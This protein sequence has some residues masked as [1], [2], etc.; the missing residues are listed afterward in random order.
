MHVFAI[1]L[2]A[3]L[4]NCYEA[5]AF[6]STMFVVAFA[7]GALIKSWRHVIP[8]A[9]AI[10]VAA[11]ITAALAQF[12]FDGYAF[13][14]LPR[15]YP[16]EQA[17]YWFDRLIIL[18][19]IIAE[20]FLVLL[21][22]SV[23]RS[24]IGGIIGRVLGYAAAVAAIAFGGS[25]IFDYFRAPVGEPL[26]PPER[27]AKI[28]R[29]LGAA[30]DSRCFTNPAQRL[31]IPTAGREVAKSPPADMPPTAYDATPL[32]QGG[33]GAMRDNG[34][35]ITP[36][37]G[38]RTPNFGSYPQDDYFVALRVVVGTDGRVL[39]AKP[40]EGPPDAFPAAIQIAERL[41][42]VPFLRDGKP[43][44]VRLEHV[45]V[46]TGPPARMPKKTVA[47]PAVGD[48]SML[49][50]HLA[51][52]FEYFNN[53]A[54]AVTI[55]GDGAVRFEGLNNVALM[56]EH[57]AL[58]APEAVDALVAAFRAADFHSLDDAYVSKTTYEEEPAV[59]V[60]ITIGEQ[61]KTVVSYNGFAAGMPNAVFHLQNMI[62]DTAAIRRWTRGDALTGPSLA[63]ERWDFGR[64]DDANRQ[65]LIGAVQFGDA[66][67]VRDLIRLGAPAARDSQGPLER[68]AARGDFE[69]V[70]ALFAS[71]TR[72]SK[73]E[74]T[75]A[76]VAIADYGSDDIVRTLVQ[77]GADVNARGPAQQSVL[78][79]AAQAG[80]PA[81]V[82]SLV[83]AGADVKATD[84]WGQTAL[85]KTELYNPELN[86]ESEFA[87]RGAVVDV[88]VDAGIGVDARSHWQQTP[89]IGNRRG[90]E[91]VAAALI[92]HGADVNAQDSDGSTPL[93][94]NG[95]PKVTEMLLAA[96]ANPFL[97][98]AKGRTLFDSRD[99]YRKADN[100]AAVLRVADAWTVAH[101]AEAQRAREEAARIG[102][103]RI[104]KRYEPPMPGVEEITS[105]TDVGGPPFE[106]IEWALFVIAQ[107]LVAFGLVASARSIL[108]AQ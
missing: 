20:M 53:P 26:A 95:N 46:P 10:A 11:H 43:T 25:A 38:F 78:A 104:P 60:S 86:I 16:I 3:C 67:A 30:R 87:D 42:F 100:F 57:C 59:A 64:G 68:A 33:T 21:V 55:R 93:M 65:M 39:A 66:A 90:H 24:A 37:E 19:L 14:W 71:P 91:G 36:I 101:P 6:F 102:K 35:L 23:A 54:Y 108:R 79:L 52:Y 99:E 106:V 75:E 80:V 2:P 76:L 17:Q 29:D 84:Q 45:F 50:I 92:A 28:V 81:P 74:L 97:I 41:R 12:A 4:P 103:T 49:R 94:T 63:A 89:L 27:V 107:M 40:V 98:D 82:A 47:F 72:W 9:V 13:G 77:R 105:I 61:T 8:A 73:N 5:P 56:G 15:E 1:E 85:H 58:I 31:D 22:L 70:R 32:L 34:R 69:M 48:K 18:A 62:D 83:Q 96:G 51:Q 44:L 88:L 7:A